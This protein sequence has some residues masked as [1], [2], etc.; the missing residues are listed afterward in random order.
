M[1]AKIRHALSRATVA[2]RAVSIVPLLRAPTFPW[3][4]PVTITVAGGTPPSLAEARLALDALRAAR[5]GGAFWDGDGDPWTQVA[6][7]AWVQAEPADDLA[8]VAW[9][10][11]VE[12]HEAAACRTREG[13]AERLDPSH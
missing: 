7:A 1:R 10:S 9:L 12:R 2:A 3:A 6:T 8:I 13:G 4:A 5:V 11:Q